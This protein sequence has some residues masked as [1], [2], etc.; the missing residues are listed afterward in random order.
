MEIFRIS[1]QKY[2]PHDPAISALSSEGRWHQKGEKVLYFSSSL[3]LCVLELKANGVSFKSIRER[4]HFSSSTITEKQTIEIV[5]TKFYKAE[6]QSSKKGSQEFGSHWFT[7]NQSLILKVKS[8]VLGHEMNF[9]INPM[10]K[11]FLSLKFSSPKAVPLDA[12]LTEE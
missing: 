3:A 1:N 8:A 2:F 12:R 4:F 10:H 5:P 7:Q 11:Q 6:W 9:I